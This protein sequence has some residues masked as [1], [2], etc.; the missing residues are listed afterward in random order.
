LL[1]QAFARRVGDGHMCRVNVG[2]PVRVSRSDRRHVVSL[3]AL[4]VRGPHEM[5]LLVITNASK[6]CPG[7]VIPLGRNRFCHRRCW[8]HP[9]LLNDTGSGGTRRPFI[10]EVGSPEGFSDALS[11]R[12]H[13]GVTPIAIP[14]DQSRHRLDASPATGSSIGAIHVAASEQLKRSC[15]GG[16]Y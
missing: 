13:T 12:E 7:R 3:S 10:G 5:R 11:F 2:R 1:V 8:L 4:Y 14:E 16:A 6:R 9:N 15:T